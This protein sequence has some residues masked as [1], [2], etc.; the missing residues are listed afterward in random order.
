MYRKC[1][2]LATKELDSTLAG[3]KLAARID[4]LHARG[5][6]TEDLKQWAH[7]V[8]LD[9]N[10]AA[11]EE[12]ELSIEEIKQLAS[13]TE[14]FLQYTFTL[15]AQVAKRQADATQQVVDSAVR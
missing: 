6:L 4:A 3:K 14:L 13:F 10:D 8:R 1:L 2:D 5:A 9:G 11:H 12:D 7:A 15:P